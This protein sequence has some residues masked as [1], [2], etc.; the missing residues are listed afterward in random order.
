[1]INALPSNRPDSK[2][3]TRAPNV[4]AIIKPMDRINLRITNSTILLLDAMSTHPVCAPHQSDR[5]HLRER[6]RSDFALLGRAREIPNDEPAS[7]N[8]FPCKLGKVL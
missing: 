8:K 7:A 4:W 2:S 3:I 6:E 5:S 1:M